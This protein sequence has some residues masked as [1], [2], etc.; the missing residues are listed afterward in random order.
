MVCLDCG[1]KNETFLI[2]ILCLAVIV[3][4]SACANEEKGTDPAL[5]QLRLDYKKETK[6]IRVEML[7][8]QNQIVQG[9]S[10]LGEEREPLDIGMEEAL[11]DTIKDAEKILDDIPKIPS[12]SQSPE[13][14]ENIVEE[15]SRGKCK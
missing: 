15:I 10:L 11:Q 13:E 5:V 7:D 3:M 14:M 12:M 4:V 2:V 6:R 9:N 8:L 1:E